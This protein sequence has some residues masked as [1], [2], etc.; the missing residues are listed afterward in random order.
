[1][2]GQVLGDRVEE[3]RLPPLD[4]ED[5]LQ[6]GR[7]AKYAQRLDKQ[8][9]SP[10]QRPLALAFY[11]LKYLNVLKIKIL[12]VEWLRVAASHCRDTCEAVTRELAQAA[13]HHDRVLATRGLGATAASPHTPDGLPEVPVFT[14][15]R[16]I[17]ETEGSHSKV[18]LKSVRK[19]LLT[20]AQNYFKYTSKVERAN[21]IFQYNFNVPSQNILCTVQC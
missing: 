10:S 6:I 13:A 17:Q 1:M 15:L 12:Q 14:F 8:V 5:A 7:V 9:H 16:P 18:Y 19:A 20:T 3:V 4:V 2:R 11:N 21:T